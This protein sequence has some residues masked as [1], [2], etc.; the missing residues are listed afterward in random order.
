MVL[1][2]ELINTAL[3]RVLDRLHPDH[4]PVVKIAKD[5]AAGAVLVS[6]VAALGVFVALLVDALLH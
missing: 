2:A 5:C 1:G 3:E 4:H 6:S